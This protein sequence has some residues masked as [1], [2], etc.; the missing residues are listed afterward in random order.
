SF[1]KQSHLS[2]RARWSSQ[3]TPYDGLI[4]YAPR[5][6]VRAELAAEVARQLDPVTASWPISASRLAVFARCGFQYLLE[7]VL[8]LEAVEEPGE[9]R[10]LDPLERGSLF[11]EVAERFLRER[12]DRGELPLRDRP[13]LRRRLQEIADERLEALVAKSPPRFTA[14]WLKERA[15]F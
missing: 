8:R 2:A 9:R 5:D 14:L 3:L 11:H 13:E 10:R 12:R 6:G 4:A 7:C 15:R 1:F